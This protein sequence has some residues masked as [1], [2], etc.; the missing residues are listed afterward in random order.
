MLTEV[1]R[2]RAQS[3]VIQPNSGLLGTARP[4]NLTSTGLI[5]RDVG[6]LPTIRRRIAAP[7]VTIVRWQALGFVIY[8]TSSA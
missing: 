3:N 6:S 8:A 5:K 2:P 1:L 4:H 7:A